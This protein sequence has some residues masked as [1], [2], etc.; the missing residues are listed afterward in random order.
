MTLCTFFPF[1]SLFDCGSI[2]IAKNVKYRTAPGR[3]DLP[4]V[5]LCLEVMALPRKPKRPCSFPGCP[6][7]TEERYCEEH[8]KLANRQYDRYSRDK[9]A[10]KLYA[11][12]EWKKIRA[13][14]LAVHPLCEQCRKE[15]RLTKATEVHHILPLRR[16]GTHDESNLMP[17][18]KPCHSRISV[19]DGDRFA[20]QSLKQE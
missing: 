20:P 16:G 14:F 2:I 3:A 4:G 5:F 15:G 9:A 17:L 6:N 12:S 19:R 8:K 18:C 13:R 7:L 11:S 1:F 10:R